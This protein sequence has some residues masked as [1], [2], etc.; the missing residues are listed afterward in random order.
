[1]GCHLM[2][3]IA[4]RRQL[5]TNATQQYGALATQ[6][7]HFMLITAAHTHTHPHKQVVRSFMDTL[8]EADEAAAKEKQRRQE[9]FASAAFSVL[10]T[11]RSRHTTSFR[12]TATGPTA[13]KSTAR[14]IHDSSKLAS[15]GDMSFRSGPHPD[16]SLVET[17]G[18]LTP[19]G[20]ASFSAVDSSGYAADAWWRDA[21]ATGVGT[22]AGLDPI[23]VSHLL[24]VH[25]T[26]TRT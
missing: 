19:H 18:M 11:A 9:A 20:S 25:D 22:P 1:M 15:A 24:R 4:P 10:S 13:S 26:H 12:S 6:P 17:S 5:S 3:F 14:G 23:Q 21:S 16:P 8:I 7:H 2:P